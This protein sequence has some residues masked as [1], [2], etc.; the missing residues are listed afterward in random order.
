MGFLVDGTHDEMIND[1]DWR[2][3]ESC[4]S[5]TDVYLKCSLMMDK[6]VCIGQIDMIKGHRVK[7]DA[8]PDAFFRCKIC[9]W[10]PLQ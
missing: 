8:D 3:M 2:D 9:G 7:S 6:F 5:F 4:P 1:T 10:K